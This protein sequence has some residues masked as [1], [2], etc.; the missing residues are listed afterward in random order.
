MPAFPARTLFDSFQYD[1][2]D[3]PVLAAHGWNARSGA[4]GPG[5]SGTWKST[6]V[7]FPAQPTARGGQ[8]L[9]LQ[10]RTDGTQRGTQQAELFSTSPRFFT[11]TLAAR[12]RFNDK[13]TNGRNGD[14]INESVFVISP[15]RSSAK[16]TELDYEYM[17]NGGWGAPGPRM[18]ITSWR[19][20]QQGDRATRARNQHLDG[21]HIL[22]ITAVKGSVT[23]TID[24]HTVFR[25]DG[26]T[27]PRER[28]G[29]HFSTWLIDLPF[30]G[31]R[32]WEM[33]VNWVY[34][35]DGQ[36]MSLTEVQ[37]AVDDLYRRNVSYVD[38][39]FDPG[40]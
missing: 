27:F 10:L 2:P 3:D 39:M 17:P 8:A 23:Y 34:G 6:G 30:S 25:S 32:T 33:Q 15:N 5:I 4:G 22:M 19:S 9:Q 7:S 21:W 40:A 36:A 38:T 29:I 24:G 31:T 35:K 26:K 16:Y 20:S 13:P 37:A 12:I 1:G 18:D 14:H 11:G 28:T